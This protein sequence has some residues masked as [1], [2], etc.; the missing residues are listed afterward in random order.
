M[1]NLE[2]YHPEKYTEISNEDILFCRRKSVGIV[3]FTFNY[4]NKNFKL[5]DVGGQSK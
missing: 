3:E 1:E 4:G 5:F 2:R